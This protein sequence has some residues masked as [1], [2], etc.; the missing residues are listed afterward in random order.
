MYRTLLVTVALA[1]SSVTASAETINIT[2]GTDP[3]LISEII[4]DAGT[5][6]EIVF[7]AGEHNLGSRVHEVSGFTM[8]GELDSNGQLVSTLRHEYLGPYSS[9]FTIR[10]GSGRGNAQTEFRDLVIVGGGLNNLLDVEL[11]SNLRV[12]NCVISGGGIQ[13]SGDGG[14]VRILPHE[15][16]EAAVFVGCRFLD[17]SD[18]A[19][20]VD[21]NQDSII[22]E[23]CHFEGNYGSRGGA[24]Y[25]QDSVLEI[26]GCAFV[27]N[28]GSYDGGAISGWYGNQISITKSTFANN[29]TSG[30]GDAIYMTVNSFCEVVDSVFCG[31]DVCATSGSKVS[32]VDSHLNNVCADCD[33]DEVQDFIQ[34]LNND[35]LDCDGNGVLD[36][37]EIDRRDCD[38]NGR[39]DVC[40][41]ADGAFDI[42]E[43]DV[44]DVCQ[45]RADLDRNG[46]VEAADLGLL[47]AAW[48]T[49]GSVI[50]DSDLDGDG[51]VLASDLGL[52]IASWG[53]CQ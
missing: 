30:C 26:V 34:I 21:N 43:D 39:I 44:L 8:R 14:A 20:Y 16:I 51:Y 27:E 33:G 28:A 35:S 5:G 38:G 42:D 46:Y 41:L 40:D 25:T 10:G 2:P 4:E 22:F 37:C 1:F 49:D 19:I 32:I 23:N 52:L 53:P 17:N 48:G 7:L 6:D 9:L 3:F 50:D 13:N 47:I 45:C 36:S 24:I 29:Q 18:S 31:N 12:E 11:W 15:G